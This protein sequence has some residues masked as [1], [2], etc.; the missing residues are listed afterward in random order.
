MAIPH[1]F[2]TRY[3]VIQLQTQGFVQQNLSIWYQSHSFPWLHA[4][5][6]KTHST[7][8][9]NEVIASL[10]STFDHHAKDIQE[11]YTHTLNKMNQ[12]LTSI[13]Q[14]LSASDQ[15]RSSHSLRIKETHNPNSSILS[16]S[17]PMK[18]DFPR[19]LG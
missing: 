17:Q 13:L 15:S 11:I 4:S 12:H 8:A 18:L 9:T 2:H 19:F 1:C 5:M 10:H 7:I 14:K 16:L 6:A 3:P